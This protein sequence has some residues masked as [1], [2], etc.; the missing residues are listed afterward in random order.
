[1]K[2]YTYTLLVYYIMNIFDKFYVCKNYN[3]YHINVDNG[4]T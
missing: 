1:V 4:L 2:N 3:S